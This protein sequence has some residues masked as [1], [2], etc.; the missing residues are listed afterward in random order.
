MSIAIQQLIR[1][2]FTEHVYYHPTNIEKSHLVVE[3]V[4]TCCQ[5]MAA[6]DDDFKLQGEKDGHR[7]EVHPEP[8]KAHGDYFV[9][10]CPPLSSLALIVCDPSY[11]LAPTI[12]HKIRIMRSGQ[13]LPIL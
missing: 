7:D 4:M 2:D 9:G 8:T 1:S 6:E 10:M 5:I 3:F 11:F 13:R 12:H